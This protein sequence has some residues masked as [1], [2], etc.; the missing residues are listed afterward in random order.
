MSV[1]D[2]ELERH[3]GRYELINP[4]INAN[5]YWECLKDAETP[6]CF[7]TRWGRIGA[8][9]TQRA[10]KVGC[11]RRYTVD[12]LNE[13]LRE[14]YRFACAIDESVQLRL[15]NEQTDRLEENTAQVV[16]PET[17]AAPAAPRRGRL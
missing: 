16:V 5:K 17:V 7:G 2:H 8:K 12:K 14:G 3:L 13:K 6:G 10:R 9:N 1:Y 15:A 4:A 11:S